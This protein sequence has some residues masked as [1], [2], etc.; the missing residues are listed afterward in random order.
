MVKVFG[1]VMGTKEGEDFLKLVRSD[2]FFFCYGVGEIVGSFVV[3]VVLELILL[4]IGVGVG[5]VVWIVWKCFWLIIEK[6]LVV[7]KFVVCSKKV[8]L[9]FDVSRKSSVEA[10]FFCGFGDDFELQ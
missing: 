9:L 7:A 1:V 2:A 4:V 6:I 3:E 5:L 10:G 8:K